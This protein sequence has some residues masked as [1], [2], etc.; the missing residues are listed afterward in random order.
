M[1]KSPPI[2]RVLVVDDHPLIR[3]GIAAR[4]AGEKD[5]AVVGEAADAA[6]ALVRFRALRP[7]IVLMDLPM[8]DV[9]GH[10][11]TAA[12]VELDAH[13]RIVVL[14]AFAGDLRARRAFAAGA[15][16]YL[17]KSHVQT[18]LAA[19]IRAVMDGKRVIDPEVR[20]QLAA[21][22][23]DEDLSARELAVLR[24]V[25]EGLANREIGVRLGISEGTVKNHVKRILG[26]LGAKDRTHAVV[27]GIARGVLDQP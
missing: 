2:I 13:S 27:I 8:L 16:A 7:D 26:K 10:D 24:L 15:R 17:L 12:I 11:A 18:N 9:S 5:M 4:L 25:G 14:T 23:N 19:T 1:R 20:R 3:Q 21:R 22:S 6:E